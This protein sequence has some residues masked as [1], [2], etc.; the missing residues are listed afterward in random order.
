ML[1]DLC[2]C[3]SGL[4]A[5]AVAPGD[6]AEISVAADIMVSRGTAERFMCMDCWAPLRGFQQEMF[7]S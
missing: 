1:P 6:A 2:P 3:N 7:G 5:I 4:P